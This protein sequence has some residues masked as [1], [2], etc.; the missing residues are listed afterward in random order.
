MHPLICAVV[1]R[2]LYSGMDLD[3]Y[4]LLPNDPPYATAAMYHGLLGPHSSS[5]VIQLD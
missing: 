2:V 1:A 4:R 5:N 3:L